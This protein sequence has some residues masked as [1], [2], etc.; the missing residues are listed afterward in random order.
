MLN[1]CD[2]HYTT[3][4]VEFHFLSKKPAAVASDSP[5]EMQVLGEDGDAL[6]VHGAEIGV[7]KEADE[8]GLRCLLQRE[9]CKRLE[10]KVRLEV[11]GHL[12]NEALKWALEDEKL[13]RFLVAANLAERHGARTVSVG[14]LDAAR[15]GRRLARRQRRQT[16]SP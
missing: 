13:R 7:L 14:L 2:R 3:A 12:T 4:M 11:L 15:C 8:V 1:F 16:L 6:G 5:R 9:D 10:A